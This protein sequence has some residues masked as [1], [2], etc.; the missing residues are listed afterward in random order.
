[1][2]TLM[3]ISDIHR[4]EVDFISNAELLSCLLT[5]RDRYST[6]NPSISK[7]DAIEICGDLIQGLPLGSSD[8]PEALKK[9]YE[10]AFDLLIKIAD[11]FVEGDRSKVIIIPGNHDVDWNLARSAMEAVDPKDQY[12]PALLTIKDS[13]YKWCWKDKV[14]FQITNQEVYENRFK[15]FYDI[16]SRFYDGD[17]LAFPLDPKRYWNLFE[18]DY[19]RIIIGAFNSCLNNDCF[20]LSGEISS[21]TISDSHL[22]LRDKHR[23]DSLKIAVWHHSV[24]GPPHH[25]DYMALN[26]V[27][28]MI[29]R[30][31]RLGIHGHQHKSDALPYSINTSK[32]QTM[33]L[34]STGSL[35]AGSRELPQ[36]FT[37]QYNIIEIFDNYLKARIHVRDMKIPGIFSPGRVI[38]L[39][40]P[41]FV[42]LEWTEPP[43]SHIVNTGL[44]GGPII[45]VIE[46]IENLIKT[47]CYKDA[48]AKI[49]SNR[50]K[51]GRYGRNLLTEAL[52][53]SKKWDRL[54]EHLSDPQNI[55]ELTKFL[56]GCVALK[57]W[58]TGKNILQTAIESGQY[59][60]VSIRE[61]YNWFETERRMAI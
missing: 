58:S 51:L 41:S 40:N 6:E 9:Q 52:I 59:S 44:G 46:E 39:G 12:I 38:T 23:E 47:K 1:M 61:L 13:P 21:K 50:G 27:K 19:G 31:Y 37:R 53:G 34:I 3:H 15:Y 10:E 30:G 56:K 55:D 57:K 48:I 54:V 18:L 32:K 24:E 20:N 43:L 7:P 16:F 14:L 28:L 45:L 36:G 17:P 22:E 35:C 49:D 33:A 60:T 4:S 25:S 8:Y 11:A 42:D 26:T 2:Y 5:D 29:D